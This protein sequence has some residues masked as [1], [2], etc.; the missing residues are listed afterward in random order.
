MKSAVL[1]VIGGDRYRSALASVDVAVL[2]ALL[3]LAAVV[4]VSSLPFLVTL[5]IVNA[6]EACD[7]AFRAVRRGLRKYVPRWARLP[8]LRLVT[9]RPDAIRVPRPRSRRRWLRRRHAAAEFD[10]PIEREWVEL[11]NATSTGQRVGVRESWY[12]RRRLV[13][14]AWALRHTGDTVAAEPAGPPI[15]QVAADL[16]RLGRQRLGIATRSPV[17]FAA[18]Q[19]AYDDRLSVACRELGIEQ[20]LADVSGVDLDIERV[21]VEGELQAAGMTLGDSEAGH[22]QDR[23]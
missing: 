10:D 2:R 6:E 14:L 23:R 4:A 5:A 18:V 17:W 21:R 12:R 3:L 8:L 9:A 13:R 1:A 16:R 11:E 7:R 19:R 15:E 22:Q 20:H